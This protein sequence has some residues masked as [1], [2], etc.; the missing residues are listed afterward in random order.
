MSTSRR[1][2][3]GSLA[4][5]PLI[6]KTPAS[7]TPVAAWPNRPV[8]LVVTFAPGGSTDLVARLLAQGLQDRLGQPVI[9]ENRAG[10]G[11]TT[12][13]AHVARAEPDGYTYVFSSVSVM[14]VG[15]ALYRN[16]QYDPM[17]D[18]AHVALVC[19][20]HQVFVANPQFEGRNLA[21][22]IRL[23]RATPGGLDMASSGAGSLNHLFIVHFANTTGARLNHVAYRGAGPA[24]TAVISGEVPLMSDSL[25]SAAS[26]IRQGMVR[27]LGTPGAQRSQQFPEIPTF[28]EQGVDIVGGSWFGLATPA[29]TPRAIVE[30]MNREVRAVLAT[31]KVRDRLSEFVATP[32][33]LSVE[34]FTDLVQRD[35]NHWGP[36]VKAS[37]AVVD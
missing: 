35:Y 19:Y 30:R 4:S 21:D 13:T 3:L 29:G 2:M 22:L 7:A 32:G 36:I 23:S 12:A 11:G 28:K 16:I 17:R 37:G 10:A 34:E 8:R 15:P 24:M 31:S 14:A 1:L 6:A 33:N 5:T 27:P 26:Y 9:V 25:P 18:F 20:T